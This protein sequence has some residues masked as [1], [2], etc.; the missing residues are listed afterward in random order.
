[1]TEGKFSFKNF[2]FNNLSL[3]PFQPRR[4]GNSWFYPL[5]TSGQVFG[6]LDNLKQFLE[7]PELNSIINIRARAMSSWNLQVV[8]KTTGLEQSNNQSLVKILKTP[9]WF[10]G[11]GEFWR[12][13]SL[14]RDIYGNEFLFFL[15]PIGMLISIKGMFTLDPSKIEIKYTGDAAFFHEPT[16]DKIKYIYRL[17]NGQT[18]DIDI[19]DIIHLNDNRVSNNNNLFGNS[20]FLS[21]TSKMNSQA[22]PINNI[23]KAYEKRGIV[24]TMPVGILSNSQDDAIGQAVP[25]DPDEKE[26]L[27]KTLRT[28]GATPIITDLATKYNAMNVNSQTMGLFEEVREDLG[29][30]CDA[31]GV[32]YALLAN[33]QRSGIGSKGT[34]LKESRK[35]FFEE[36]IIPDA[37]EK[38]DALNLHLDT[39]NKS[40]EVIADFKHLPVFSEDVKNRAS[41]VSIMVKALSQALSDGAISL[42]QY[43]KELKKFNI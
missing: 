34:E 22:A 40:W 13:S 18:I 39:A 20:S 26:E 2:S 17:L 41:S 12:Q 38:V 9:N 15:T 19:K 32:P 3:N 16:G 36:T 10:Q 43:K 14:F 4:Q 29:S 24:L 1:M 30:L 25:H 31:Y 35:Q 8:S 37:K 28:R 21:G 6:E 23:R 33:A 11:Q 42:E 27:Q 5:S 7:I